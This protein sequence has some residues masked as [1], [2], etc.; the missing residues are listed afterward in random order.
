MI[1]KSRT[2]LKFFILHL[3]IFEYK[4]SL[5]NPIKLRMSFIWKILDSGQIT[6]KYWPF[7]KCRNT[8]ISLIISWEREREGERERGMM[9]ERINY[10]NN[11]NDRFERERE[12]ERERGLILKTNWMTDLRER[13]RE[14]EREHIL[15]YVF[16]SLSGIT[17]CI[18]IILSLS[19][20]DCV[21]KVLPVYT[22]RKFLDFSK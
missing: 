4:L 8:Q 19:L 5:K 18:V 1:K 16:P 13:E 14:R 17:H 10:E 9:S 22:R 20:V 6:H 11:L 12:R 15:I 3:H 21:I 2:N 7:L